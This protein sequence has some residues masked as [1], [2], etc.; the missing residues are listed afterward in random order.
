M[1]PSE[2]RDPDLFGELPIVLLPDDVDIEA[3]VV[4]SKAAVPAAS[5]TQGTATRAPLAR[6]TSASPAPPSEPSHTEPDLTE[7]DI[8][9]LDDSPTPA[10]FPGSAAPEPAILADFRPPATAVAIAEPPPEIEEI[11]PDEEDLLRSVADE[12]DEELDIERRHER[13]VVSIPRVCV[14]TAIAASCALLGLLW[15]A[16][17]YYQL[18]VAERPFHHLHHAL[19]SSGSVGLS[20]GVLGTLL[21]ASTL[22]Y[23][24]RKHFL[25]NKSGSLQSWMGLHVLAGTLGPAMVLFHA[26]FLP[27]SVL[28]LLAVAAM[29]IVVGSGTMGRYFLAYVPRAMGGD[30]LDEQG[31]RRRLVVYRR[32]LIELGVDPTWLG[33]EEKARASGGRRSPWFVQALFGVIYG[34]RESRREFQRLRLVTGTEGML[35]EQA[36]RIVILVRRLCRE[37][38]WLV[39][40]QELRKLVGAWRFLHRWMTILLFATVFFHI[41]VALKFGDLPRG[42]QS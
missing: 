39:R 23:L 3:L 10:L 6:S 34:D 17:P 42:G 26:N 40:Y 7:T 19:R 13:R 11:E 33:E 22:V 41:V 15:I 37:R 31:V 12:I 35:D 2:E 25:S 9:E 24:I 16:W 18:S 20:L 14:A 8:H 21:M 36:E 30:E 5:S 27:T 1:N 29:L 4:S 28:G 32:K 38:Q